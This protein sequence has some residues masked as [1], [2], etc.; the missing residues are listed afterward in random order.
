M[1]IL[2][3]TIYYLLLLCIYLHT[4]HLITIINIVTQVVDRYIEYEQIKL[5]TCYILLVNKLWISIEI[6]TIWSVSKGGN[7]LVAGLE[8]DCE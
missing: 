3:I 4:I 5:S 8:L 7:M 1:L 2:S 6:M